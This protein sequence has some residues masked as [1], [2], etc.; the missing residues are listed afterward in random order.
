LQLGFNA[1]VQHGVSGWIDLRI[2]RTSI[3]QQAIFSA[4]LT[5]QGLFGLISE[6]RRAS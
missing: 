6:I 2:A 3:A 4:C 5:E 1:A